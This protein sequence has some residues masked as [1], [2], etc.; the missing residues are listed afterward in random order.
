MTLFLLVEGSLFL[1]ELKPGGGGVFD[2]IDISGH[3]CMEVILRLYTGRSVVRATWFVTGNYR[4]Y[5]GSF[6]QKVVVPSPN[7]RQ[8]KHK[9]FSVK[10]CRVW[11]TA[12]IYFIIRTYMGHFQKMSYFWA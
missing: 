11:T 1:V 2:I 6:K 7:A 9:D 12:Y 4:S 8:V 10:K 3:Y 5:H